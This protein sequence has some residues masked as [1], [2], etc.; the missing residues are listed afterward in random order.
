MHALGRCRLI[1]R[2]TVAV[3]VMWTLLVLLPEG[4][5]K[6]NCQQ[7]L[8]GMLHE[9]LRSMFP[10]ATGKKCLEFEVKQVGAT[11]R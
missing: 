6:R 8:D 3:E 10:E 5:D 11:R 2:Q 9:H 7:W 1:A 4:M